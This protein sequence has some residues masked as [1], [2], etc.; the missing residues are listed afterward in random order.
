MGTNDRMMENVLKSIQAK[1]AL[2]KKNL[3]LLGFLIETTE[4]S[5]NHSSW[6]HILRC[7]FRRVQQLLGQICFCLQ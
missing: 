3:Q 6:G 5:F 1:V 2:K 7:N 4:P